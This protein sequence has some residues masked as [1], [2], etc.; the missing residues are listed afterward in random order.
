MEQSVTPADWRLCV[1]LPLSAAKRGL[2]AKIKEQQNQREKLQ[3]SMIQLHCVYKQRWTRERLQ[4]MHTPWQFLMRT[5][6]CV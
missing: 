3:Y 2:L 4:W 6:G 1:S 5:V